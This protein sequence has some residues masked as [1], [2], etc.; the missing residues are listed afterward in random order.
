MQERLLDLRPLPMWVTLDSSL[1]RR[2]WSLTEAGAHDGAARGVP[3]LSR[4]D[5]TFD[6]QGPI[7]RDIAGLWWVMLVLGTAVYVVFLALLALALFRRRRISHGPDGS[8][9]RLERRW[10]VGGGV[11]LSVALLIA[12]FVPTIETMRDVPDRGGP[13]ALVV[14]IVGRQW[15]Y[16]VRYP[17]EGVRVTNL[18]HLPVGRPVELRLTSADVIHSFW[19][20]ELAGKMD[21]LPDY[22]NTLVVQ[23]DEPGEH[24]SLCAEFCGL[25]HADMR[26]RVVVESPERFAA[27]ISGQQRGPGAT[28]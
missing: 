4:L 3:V 21:M 11:V 16:D 13:G 5:G 14:E 19:V 7:A 24:L 2:W 28:G 22:A 17:D 15:Q 12:V 20:P 10:I 6:P 1:W 23:A 9:R 26:L 25:H 18:L 8:E 27:W